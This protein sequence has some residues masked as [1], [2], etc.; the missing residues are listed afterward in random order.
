MYIIFSIVG[1]LALITVAWRFASRR[2]SLPCP[3]WLSWL[4]EMDNPF[5]KTNRAAVIIEHLAVEPGMT[6]LDAGCG[7]GRLTIPLAKRVG[8]QGTVVALD[9]QPG[10]L[11]RTE[12]KT[13]AEGLGNI[14]FLCAGIGD[15]QLEHNHFDRVLLVTVLGEIPDRETA[16]REVFDALKPGGILSVT[17]VI[18]DPHF[19]NRQTTTR[20]AAQAGLREKA[21]FGHRLAYT[22]HFEKG[23]D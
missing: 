17:E 9:L 15:G 6:V 5:T 16:L 12:Q 11:K 19:Q 20:L 23:T 10:M 4:V 1:I 7:P 2:S 21:C 18:F 13:A 3:V 22:V 8:P 14:R